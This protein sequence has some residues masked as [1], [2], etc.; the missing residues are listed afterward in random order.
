MKR[1][2]SVTIWGRV[3]GGCS[4]A[5]S[6]SKMNRVQVNLPPLRAGGYC[7]IWLGGRLPGCISQTCAGTIRQSSVP[8]CWWPKSMLQRAWFHAA[9][10][11]DKPADQA[12]ETDVCTGTG[13]ESICISLPV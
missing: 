4:A 1:S 6:Q 13:A 5:A 3:N 12:E 7:V 2:D 9:A 11:L 10:R 8:V